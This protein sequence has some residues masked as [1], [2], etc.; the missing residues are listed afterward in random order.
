MN[1]TEALK[2]IAATEFRP[3]T[4]SDFQAWAG[5]ETENPMYGENG[6]WAIVLDGDVVQFENCGEWFIFNLNLTFEG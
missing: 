6:D 3:F 2:M 5:V 1:A 4:E